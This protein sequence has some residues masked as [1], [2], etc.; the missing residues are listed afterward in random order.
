MEEWIDIDE[1]KKYQVSSLG[2]VRS[3][4]RILKL[5][6]GEH[7]YQVSLGKGN[8]SLV[9]R[10]VCSAF[11]KNPEDKRTVNHLNGN[12]LDNRK[13]NV[14]WATEQEQID[15]AIKT[16]LKDH[17]G[18]KSHFA[19]LTWLQVGVIREAIKHGH[20]TGKIAKYFKVHRDTIGKIKS[21][22]N[23]VI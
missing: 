21:N 19:I 4:R 14:A 1:H 15:H 23:W 2:R 5:V 18:D 11:H 10:L 20:K 3:P 16:G 8:T 17:A 22:Q 13:E 9:H 7:Y 12:K 6:L